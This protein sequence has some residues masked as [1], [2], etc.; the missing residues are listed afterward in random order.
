MSDPKAHDVER[1]ATEISGLKESFKAALDNNPE[2]L[3][4]AIMDAK[5]LAKKIASPPDAVSNS[6]T[7]QQLQARLNR[8]AQMISVAQV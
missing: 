2:I 5:S 4:S 3:K 7:L 8:I 6:E 1:L